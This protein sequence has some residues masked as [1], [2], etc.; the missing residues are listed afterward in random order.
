MNKI[1]YQYLVLYFSLGVSFSSVGQ[2]LPKQWSVKNSHYIVAGKDNHPDIYDENTVEE[3]RLYFSQSNYWSL[4]TQN[5]NAKIDIPVKLKYKGIEYDSV[6]IRFKGQTSYTRNNTPKKSF[7]ISMDQYKE[8]Q[9]LLGYKTLNLNNAFG[10]NSYMREVL[11]YHYVR[12]YSPSAKANFVRLYINDEDWGIYSNVQQLNKTFIKEWYADD[13]GINIRADRPDGTSITQPGGGGGGMWGDGTAAMNYLGQDTSL[14][15]KY[16]E[17]K[18]SGVDNTWQKLVEGTNILNNTIQNQRESIYPQLFDIDK[19]LWHLACENI[20]VDDDSYVFKGKMDYY[21]YFDRITERWASYDYDANSSIFNNRA[22]QWDPFYNSNNTNYPFLNKILQI[23]AFRQRYLAHYRT[24][25][26]EVLEEENWNTTIEKYNSL[27]K[28]IVN[29]EKKKGISFNQYLT[30]VNNI[31]TFARNRKLF[32]ANNSEL[33]TTSPTL[34]NLTYTVNKKDFDIV[35]STDEVRVTVSVTFAQGVD[36]V[37]LHYG[38]GFDNKF[39]EMSMH[40]DGKNGDQIPNDGV[41]TG[42]IPAQKASTLIKFYSEAIGKNSAQSRNYLPSGCEH[43]VMFYIVEGNPFDT[44]TI[45]VNEFMATNTGVVKDPFGENEDW[46]EL[47]N[48]TD[49][50]IDMKGY[51]IS[52]NPTNSRKFR[53]KENTIIKANGYL[54]IWADEN[55]SQGPLHVNFKLAAGGESIILSDSNATILDSVTFGQQVSNQSAA[56][57]PNGTGNFVIGAHTLNKN[58]EGLNDIQDV[59]KDEELLVYPI[60]NSGDFIVEN[61]GENKL[62]IILMDVIGR[63]VKEISLDSKE[64]INI[65]N[66]QKGIYYVKSNYSMIKVLVF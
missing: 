1:V 30:E 9:N 32:L 33:N 6:G 62:P 31:K 49:Q 29:Q 53:F 40:D 3:I 48:V 45:V 34:S 25:I 66:V 47:Y 19:I 11:Y 58:N 4:L 64:K 43:E 5:Y 7:N 44:K 51:Y 50:D 60:P 16:Y 55:G 21:L 36:K 22:N 17:L 41:Y 65:E 18:S 35:T 12:K 39:T 20:F 26:T 27:L 37:N 57:I 24:L 28:N 13:D 23:P 63:K 8:D 38:I 15:Q 46:I 42:V 2:V 14:Y 54:I 52:D 10:D 61:K 59:Y 56:R